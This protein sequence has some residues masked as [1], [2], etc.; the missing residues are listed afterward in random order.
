MTAAAV[1]ERVEGRLY[2]SRVEDRF[3]NWV[4]YDW[5]GDRLDAIRAN[6]GR[7]IRLFY[8]QA[9][10]V[11][12]V[13]NGVRTWSYSYSERSVRRP[14]DNKV[15]LTAVSLPGGGSWG[16]ELARLSEGAIYL[17]DNDWSNQPAPQSCQP[18]GWNLPLHPTIGVNG[19]LGVV[20][21]PSG[22]EV[23]YLLQPRRHSSEGINAEGFYPHH[24]TCFRLGPLPYYDEL[25]LVQKEVVGPHASY[26]WSYDYTKINH[27]ADGLCIPADQ[28]SVT[29]P[30]G[31]VLRSVFGVRAS[32]DMRWLLSTELLVGGSVEERV[33]YVKEAQAG[34]YPA[35]IGHSPMKQ[36][37][38]SNGFDS[39]INYEY[40]IDPE[41]SLVGKN[42]PLQKKTTKRGGSIFAWT[43]L[44]FDRFAR[45]SV[46]SKA[47]SL[48]YSQEERFSY[49]DDISRWVIGL[50]A[51][52]HVAGLEIS[53]R[54]FDAGTLLPLRDFSYQRLAHSLTHYPDGTIKTVT[55]GNSRT[56][57]VSNW[58]RGIPQTIHYHDGSSESA[59]VDDN[60][61]IRSVT[62]EGGATTRYDYDLRGRLK[63]IDYPDGDSVDW[64]NTVLDFAQVNADEYGI[65][66]GHWRQ[67]VTTGNQ[68]K[69]TYFDGLWRP[70]VEREEDLANPATVR[71]SGKRFD[72]EGR[73]TDAYY[74]QPGSLTSHAQF[75]KGVHSTYDALG[76]VTESRQDAEGGSVLKTSTQYLPGLETLVIDPRNQQTRTRFAAL[77]QP[78]YE[79][80]VKQYLPEG[81]EVT[82]A[83]DAFFKPIQLSRGGP[84]VATVDRFYFYDA[85]QRLCRTLEP[86]TGSSVTA[87]D[88][89]SNVAWTASGQ[90]IW[91]EGCG[92]DA[93]QPAHRIAHTYDARNRLTVRDVPGTNADE[94]FQYGPSGEVK[95]ARLGPTVWDYEYNKR[96]LLTKEIL[97]FDGDSQSVSY[98]YDA[99]GHLARTVYPSGRSIDYAPN[100]LGQP[101]Q[102]GGYVTGVRYTSDGA[103]E[104]YRYGN[105]IVFSGRQNDRR[106]PSNLTYA[107]GNG[108][109]LYSQDL[110]YDA[111]ANLSTVSDLAGNG[112]SRSKTLG[113]DGLNRLTSAVAP[114]LWGTE[115]YRY[116]AL[117]NLRERLKDGQAYVYNYDALN[118]L[119]N[120]TAG[121]NAVYQFGY[122]LRGNVTAKNSDTLIF[123]Q[124]NRLQAHNGKQS[125]AYD[126]WGRRVRKIDL[127]TGAETRSLYNKAGQLLREH[128]STA[129]ARHDYLYLGSKMVGKVSDGV[130]KLT[131][132]SMSGGGHTLSW[133][134][135]PSAVR[136]IVEESTNF[137]DWTQAYSGTATTWSAGG[138][139]PGTYR[140]R[141]RMCRAD[142][143]CSLHTSPVTVKVGVNLIP[144]IYELLLN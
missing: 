3:G 46:I 78:S 124:V 91:G 126:A 139:S 123:D 27:C 50:P 16:Y 37:D 67:T 6:D 54:E 12:R 96:G 130:P 22:V 44:A 70:L 132:P 25:S 141:V 119:S 133:E 5:V 122:D 48:G 108:T 92:H 55:D 75:A 42:R 4:R 101:T 23:R 103:P 112:P 43:A 117:D 110:S 49:V 11:E 62:D 128:D 83:R 116:D 72:H 18:Y 85:H 45:P 88:G 64:A 86:E 2:A 114:A 102:V 52:N 74:P 53:R 40:T 118:R 84:N 115:T 51:A 8:N 41:M 77:D 143:S 94:G 135:S 68:R 15:F 58:K 106:L 104:A 56:T 73:V 59:S 99:L 80:P 1:M 105:G 140:Y 121:G 98:G 24:P 32:Q 13:V 93:T 136:Y 138:K 100:A 60:G 129:N 81:V 82:I 127:S 63:L 7:E 65:G 20:K 97:G 95:Q 90:S 111:N 26:K 66:P 89:A 34:I 47:N 35:R 142:G 69:T 71:V 109:L 19:E 33:D 39:Y 137:G 31:A 38:V 57:T 36:R 144:I 21:A 79:H 125:Y 28:V 14:W 87:Y 131:A 10:V 107:A 113:Y 120:V 17:K 61:W 76:R 134:A 29:K 30:D 9:G